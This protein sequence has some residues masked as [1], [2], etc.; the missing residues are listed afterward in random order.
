[1]S[2]SNRY[3]KIAELRTIDEILQEA[4]AIKRRADLDVST[5]H[6]PPSSATESRL[7]QIWKDVLALDE[8]GRD[9]TLFDL[10]GDSLHITQILNR[11]RTAFGVE[12]S[13]DA[14]FEGPTVREL[15]VAVTSAEQAS[16]SSPPS[17]FESA[18]ATTAVPDD[19]RA[20]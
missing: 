5:P 4:L 9:D 15:A 12:V 17:D 2:V 6:V 3:Q 19:E 10:G 16:I 14:F 13:I 18:T 1:M 7:V 20:D 11:M 8:V